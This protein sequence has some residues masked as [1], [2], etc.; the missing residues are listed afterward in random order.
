MG[1]DPT[2]CDQIGNEKKKWQD[3]MLIF[4]DFHYSGTPLFQIA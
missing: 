2:G 3:S 1:L 4:C